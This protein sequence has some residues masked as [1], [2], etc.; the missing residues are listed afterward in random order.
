MSVV[1]LIGEPSPE[2][3][4]VM[5]CEHADNQLPPNVELS[6]KEREWL[7]DHWGWDIG[8]ERLVRALVERESAVAVLSRYSRLMCDV[9]RHHES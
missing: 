2:T 1:E 7:E 8:A 9:N 4:L 5:T 6:A 3:S